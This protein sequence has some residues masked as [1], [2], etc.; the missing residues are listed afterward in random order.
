MRTVSRP[1]AE[2]S[3]SARAGVERAGWVDALGQARG[4]S[5]RGSARARRQT[6]RDMATRCARS[7][8]RRA[9]DGDARKS[10]ATLRRATRRASFNCFAKRVYTN[11]Y[12]YDARAANFTANTLR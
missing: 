3:S 6:R 2:T 7:Q 1:P 10:R 9:R 8:A 12:D 4:G 11:F 5:T